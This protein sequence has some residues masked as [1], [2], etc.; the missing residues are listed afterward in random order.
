MIGLQYSYINMKQPQVYIHP[1]PP[2]STSHLPSISTPPGYYRD[3]FE[4]PASYGKFPL[5]TYLHTL[6][7]ERI[8]LQYR[9]LHWI[10]GLRRFP[11]ERI[12]YPLQYSWASLVI[13]TI[14]N[15]LSMSE[16][17][18]RSLGWQD[19]LEEGMATHHSILAWRIPMDRGAWW[20][21]FH[22]VAES[23]TTKRLITTQCLCIHVTLSIYLT[24]SLFSPTMFPQSV[25][26]F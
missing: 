22:G 13:Q 24:F 4:F 8:C 6:V 26:Y 25:L 21:T 7:W 18:V 3:L 23:D 14:K 1:L 16:N 20:A 11:R 19:P 10:P 12:G 5:A 15:P 2:E 9:R 17:W